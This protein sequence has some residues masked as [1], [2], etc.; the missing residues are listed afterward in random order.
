MMTRRFAARPESVADAVH[1]VEAAMREDGLSDDMIDRVTLATGEAAGNAV[2]HGCES[3]AKRFFEVSWQRASDGYWLRVEDD[4]VGLDPALL[5]RAALPDDPF[6]TSGR[7]LYLMRA[8]ADEIQL[9]LG[10]RRIALRFSP[11]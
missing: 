2:E 6:S 1:A 9:E 5:E 7:G 8:L 11:G 4:G 10:G 3:N